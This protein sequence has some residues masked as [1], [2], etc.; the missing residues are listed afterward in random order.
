MEPDDVGLNPI[1]ELCQSVRWG[2]D[3]GDGVLF[4]YFKNSTHELTII[5]GRNN[6]CLLAV[7]APF[8]N[9]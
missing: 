6:N 5:K 3:G 2:G 1:F 9:A 8:V 7:S 4:S